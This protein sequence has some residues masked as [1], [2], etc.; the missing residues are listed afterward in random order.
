MKFV[1]PLVKA[2]LLRRYKR[3]LADVELEDGSTITLHCPNTGAMTGCSEPGS[4]V[5]FSTSDNPARKYP[6]TLEIVETGLGLVGVNPARANRLVAER[7]EGRDW[8]GLNEH[9]CVRSEAACPAQQTPGHS[10]RFDFCLEGSGHRTWLEVKSVTLCDVDGIGSFPDAVSARAQRHLQALCACVRGGER[11]V[12]FFCAQHSGVTLVTSAD[13]VDP[14]YASMLRQA[15][16][17][18]VE[19]LAGRCDLS[20]AGIELSTPI[21]VLLD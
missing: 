10:I 3:F 20:P 15:Q 19:I 1:R 9:D 17:E 4:T 14:V 5:W 8:P 7:L 18:G 11:A 6:G 2:V 16:R 13:A 21:P 12:L